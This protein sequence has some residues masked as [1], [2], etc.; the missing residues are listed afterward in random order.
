MR[1]IVD[2]SDPVNWSHPL[3]RGLVSWW[4]AL[5]GQ[6]RGVIFRD[7]CNRNNGTLTNGPEWNGARGRPGGWGCVR[8]TANN[9][10][11]SIGD[12]TTY[13]GLTSLTI[14]LWISLDSTANDATGRRI[15]TKWGATT[16]TRAFLL[17]QSNGDGDSL[18]FAVFSGS[19]SNYTIKTTSGV[20]TAGNHH[21]VVVT[22]IGG[23]TVAIHIDGR[24]VSLT[25]GSLGTHPTS[26]PN[27]S[28]AF[29]F[30]QESSGLNSM[31][32][33]IDSVRTYRRALS[34]NEVAAL[35]Q[36]ERQGY[37]GLLNRLPRRSLSI[38]ADSAQYIDN[39]TPILWHVLGA[40]PC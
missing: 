5:Q 13:D 31:L 38:T 22:W 25:D 14:S 36:E 19:E 7:L 4:L 24:S 20:L 21:H 26:I 39:T 30:G 27:S 29:M 33:S 37:P 2:T 35:I 9:H 18:T 12:V 8:M 16:A 15:V 3:N 6:Q 1:R 10:N 28:S 40:A 32:G 17:S 23:G 34:A 11:V